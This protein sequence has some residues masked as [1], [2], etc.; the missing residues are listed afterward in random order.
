MPVRDAQQ[1]GTVFVPTARLLP[2]LGRLYHRHDELER[3]GAIHFL[4]DDPFHFLQGP[5][6]HRK[7]AVQTGSQA[8]DESG[9]KHELVTDHL[10]FG[11]RFLKGVDRVLREPHRVR[12]GPCQ[13][14][15]TG[16]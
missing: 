10:R 12:S 13:S 5:Q 15:G 16:S 11:W 7:P 1:L 3:P 4:A 6:S 8:A 2:Q 14:G 9:P